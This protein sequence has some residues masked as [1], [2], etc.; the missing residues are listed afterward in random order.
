M[1][2]KKKEKEKKKQKYLDEH[3]VA[4]LRKK[5]QKVDETKPK[6]GWVRRRKSR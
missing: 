6:R 1:K 5:A 4:P 2:K 3:F